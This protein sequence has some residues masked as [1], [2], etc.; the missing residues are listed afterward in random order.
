M[1]HVKADYQILRLKSDDCSLGRTFLYSLWQL[2][3]MCPAVSKARRT[4]PDLSE[5]EASARE[6]PS[7]ITGT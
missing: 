4:F 7:L 2:P 3:F 5:R 6:L 1:S